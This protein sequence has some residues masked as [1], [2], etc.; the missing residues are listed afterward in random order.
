[1]C[2]ELYWLA[3]GVMACED[4]FTAA[5]PPRKPE[6]SYI[7]IRPDVLET[8]HHALGSTARIRALVSSRPR[9][10]GQSA[11][12]HGIQ[13]H[14]TAWL[15]GVQGTYRV[16]T[17]FLVDVIL[18][19]SG[20]FDQ[21]AATLNNPYAHE[22]RVYLATERV[23]VN[24]GRRL[25]LGVLRAQCSAIRDR[26]AQLLPADVTRSDQRGSGVPFLTSW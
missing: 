10:K 4:V 15:G 1:M 24:A 7:G 6:E 11:L 3:R 16:P 2:P 18:G 22:L 17:L 5:P 21:F 25:D 13:E 8:I 19:R 9:R 12:G 23:F 14:R 20:T 26:I